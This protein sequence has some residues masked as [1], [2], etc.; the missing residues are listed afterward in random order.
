MTTKR[1][2]FAFISSFW[3]SLKCFRVL[4]KDIISDKMIRVR[5]LGVHFILKNIII[6]YH[7]N[8]ILSYPGNMWNCR[9]T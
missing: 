8:Q 7:V 1:G 3:K 6:C 4:A 9:T 5:S 2:A